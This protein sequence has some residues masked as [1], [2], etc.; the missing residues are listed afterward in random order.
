MTSGSFF[1]EMFRCWYIRECMKPPRPEKICL[2]CGRRFSW[3]KKWADCWEE[4]KTCSQAC[5]RERGSA[6]ARLAEEAIL[7]LARER[8]PEKSLCPSEAARKL[9]AENW[10]RHMT[11]IHHAARRLA[12]SQKLRILQKEKQIDPDQ[13]RGPVRLQ[14]QTS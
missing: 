13:V 11:E 14:I 12:R 6:R 1:R 8:G 3:R 5:R 7:E 4:V 9:D 10:R 2:H